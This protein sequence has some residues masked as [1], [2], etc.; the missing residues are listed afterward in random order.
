MGTLG[1]CASFEQFHPTD[2]L[3]WSQQA[4]DAGFGSILASDHFHPWTPS[5]GQAGFVW[6]WMGALGAST[7]HVRFGPGVTA[8]GYR[9][10]PAI[11]AQASATLAAMFPGRFWLGIGSGEAL[12]EHIVGLRWPEAPTRLALLGESIEVIR[13]L[14]S[15]K[16]VKYQGQHVTLESAKLYTMPQ[17]PPPIYIATS[18]PVMSERTGRT[19]DGIITVGAADEKI[20]NLMARFEKGA[21]ETGKDPATM[22]RLIQLHVSWADS[23]EAA[24][25]QA[26]REWPNGGMNYP[27]A[28]IRNPEDFEAMA[29]LVRPEHYTGRVLISPDLDEIAAHIQH[30]IDLG[31]S[32]VYVHNVGRNQEAFIE[33]VGKRVAPQL[34]W[35]R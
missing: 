24:T 17:T 22:P 8:P 35:A 4:E 28:D 1:Y 19:A 27:K 18:G 16:V 3:R 6:A 20:A 11:L 5:Q 13:A 2:L 25:E 23:R 21:R 15:G 26:V 12:N 14:F 7:R 30:Y 10:H 33:A 34:K 31:F 32:E 9:Y 29:K